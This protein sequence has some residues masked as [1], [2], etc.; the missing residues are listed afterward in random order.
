MLA[1]M[2]G[3]NTVVFGLSPERE[4]RITGIYNKH[5][6]PTVAIPSKAAQPDL[7]YRVDADRGDLNMKGLY[8][9]GVVRY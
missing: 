9:T 4:E 2:V 8:F 7:F 5:G 6:V 3:L 1:T